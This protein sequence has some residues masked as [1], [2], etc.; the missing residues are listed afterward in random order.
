MNVNLAGKRYNTIWRQLSVYM[1]IFSLKLENG[2]PN[3][4]E[5]R[6]NAVIILGK[7]RCVRTAGKAVCK[8]IFM[9]L[10]YSGNGIA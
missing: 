8:N 1:Y 6:Q 10:C 3:G 7:S 5:Q 4:K 9:R 2:N